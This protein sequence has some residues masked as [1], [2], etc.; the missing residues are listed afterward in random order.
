MGPEEPVYSN[1]RSAALKAFIRRM[2]VQLNACYPPS[3][4]RSDY[5]VIFF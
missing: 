2:Q 4:R 3:K 1:V 5:S